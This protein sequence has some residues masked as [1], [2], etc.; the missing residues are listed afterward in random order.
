MI[1]EELGPKFVNVDLI[2]LEPNLKI[3]TLGTEITALFSEKFDSYKII[4]YNYGPCSESFDVIVLSIVTSKVR[5]SS[6]E[7]HILKKWY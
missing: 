6:E 3:V 2:L 5:L 1:A 4:D 7:Y